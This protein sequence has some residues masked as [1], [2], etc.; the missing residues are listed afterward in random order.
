[1]DSSSIG[2]LDPSAAPQH[3]F[4]ERPFRMSWTLSF[5]PILAMILLALA[6]SLWRPLDDTRYVLI[7]FG[8]AAVAIFRL[9]YV[10]RQQKARVDI[11]QYFP[12]TTWLV[13]APTLVSAVLLINGLLDRSAP[14]LHNQVVLQK[15]INHGRSTSYNLVFSSWRPGHTTEKRSVSPDLYSQFRLNDRIVIEAHKGALGIPW[16]GKIRKPGDVDVSKSPNI[17]D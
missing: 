9:R 13:W 5:V 12:L 1:M 10:Q 15:Y 14:E 8:L 11:R 16:T 4:D 7:G 3:D 2:Q 17:V 6:V